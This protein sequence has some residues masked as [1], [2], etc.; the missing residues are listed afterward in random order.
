MAGERRRRGLGPADLAWW[1]WRVLATFATPF[2]ALAVLLHP[3]LRVGWR[4]RLG[5]PEVRVEPGAVWVHAASLGEG[6]AAAALI[7]ALREREPRRAILRTWTSSTAA[8]QEVGADDT[9][10]L[11]ADT[12]FCVGAWL[13]RVR[14]SVLVLVEAELWPCLLA[15]CLDRGVPV[16]VV[17][18]RVAG[19]MGRLRRLPGVWESLSDG[20]RFLAADGETA[21]LLGAELTGDLKLDL[22]PA[23]PALEWSGRA[24]VAGST[25]AGEEDALVGAL[26]SLQEP[27]L[28]VLAP[29]DPA[30]FDEV[31]D[32]L[33]GAGWRVVRRTELGPAP[34]RVPDEADIVVLDTVGELAGLYARAEVA[35]AGGTLRQDVGGHS[36]AEALA[37]GAVLV[38]GP[39]VH[40]NPGAWDLV[41]AVV[42]AGPDDLGEKLGVALLAAPLRED[43][44]T[45]SGRARSGA[46]RR[47]VASLSLLLATPAPP[48]RPLRPWLAPA[49]WVWAAVVALRPWSPQRVGV[50][51]VS[52]GA[53][54]AG[55]AGKTPVCGW[56][57]AQG[58]DGAAAVVARGY[59]R[60]P[61]E[62]VRLRG[63]GPERP[64]G[65][66]GDAAA[67]GDELAML[68]RRGIP[69]GS[70]ADRLAVTRAVVAT[71]WRGV[72]V[73]D[74]ALQHRGLARDLEVVVVD[75]RWPTGGGLI[76]VG[77]R[78][79][80]L[81]WLRKADVVWVNHG[82][83]PAVLRP[84]VRPD[85][86]VVE[87]EY[88]PVGWLRDGV[89]HPL[90]A[91]TPQPVL[92]FAGIA[93]PASFGATLRGLGFSEVELVG[94]PDHHRFLP[95]ELEALV[96]RAAGR[97]LVCTEKDAARLPERAGVYALVI[98]AVP[99]RGEDAA[100]ARVEALYAR[101]SGATRGGAVGSA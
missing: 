41:A 93:R 40:A 62:D 48:E 4:A 30:R 73:L 59:R 6:R 19:G 46:G 12:P 17:Q 71:G 56:I 55:G 68:A 89:V 1:A 69:V 15:A 86:V 3:R 34:A 14:P 57:A 7:H 60:E 38:R 84:Y 45:A 72:V 22:P 25:H 87:A 98:D 77:T 21:R 92:A 32:A 80:P 90:F 78:R 63:V 66:A 39:Y 65:G 2:V 23:P 8:T 36:P 81:R 24:I 9:G 75:A 26:T 53:L 96:R 94:F 5:F 47:T 97:P 70:G 43:G 11:P 100:R 18:A 67:I 99:V 10:P 76:P 64:A 88:Q 50:P 83:L 28:L 35:F 16:A 91:L 54:T 31:A 13:D 42:C 58:G 44:V 52:V 20:V 51:V 37:G 61:G 79:L 49:S 74:D 33:R 85:A 29:R 82:A 101:V 27:P 95:D